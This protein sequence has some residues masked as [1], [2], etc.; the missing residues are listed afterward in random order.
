MDLTDMVRTPDGIRPYAPAR[1]H[2]DSG[3]HVETAL[4]TVCKRTFPCDEDQFE[5]LKFL[6][7]VPKDEYDECTRLRKF[8]SRKTCSAFPRP[9]RAPRSLLQCRRRR[10]PAGNPGMEEGSAAAAKK[11]PAKKAAAKKAPARKAASGE[12]RHRQKSRHQKGC[13]RRKEGPAKKA[14]KPKKAPAKKAAPR[15]RRLKRFI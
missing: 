8:S 15:K 5:L 12:K 11:A 14:R 6:G 7:G 13:Q 3:G 9:A 10:S 1:H 2:P 4:L